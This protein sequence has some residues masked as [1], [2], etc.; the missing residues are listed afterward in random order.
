MNPNN[1]LKYIDVIND[2][3]YRLSIMLS[4][5]VHLV[6]IICLLLS[7]TNTTHRNQALQNSAINTNVINAVLFNENNSNNFVQK[8]YV[9]QKTAIQPKNIAAT[10][11]TIIKEQIKEIT[12][13]KNALELR[14]KNIAKKQRQQLQKMMHEQFAA[15]QKQLVNDQEQMIQKQSLKKFAQGAQQQTQTNINAQTEGISNGLTD[16][17]S[18]YIAIIQTAIS[19]Q[20]I[21]PDK[22]VK[23]KILININPDGTVVS[24][25]IL[26][27]SGSEI[28]DRSVQAAVLKASPLPIP[29][30]QELLDKF[31]VIEL[32]I[33]PEGIGIY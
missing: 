12:E 1:T 10:E 9:I 31:R 11:E 29:K 17:E 3:T 21:K 20:W 23:G 6:I 16:K 15:E 25:K 24:T 27:S 32:N 5:C 18:E 7:N 13:L 14:K 8:K 19:S 22:K 4:V 33:N 28:L 30:E 26:I 2:R